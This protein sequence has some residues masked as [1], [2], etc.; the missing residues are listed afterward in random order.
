M[1]DFRGKGF[2]VMSPAEYAGASRGDWADG[3]LFA[4]D[5]MESGKKCLWESR[6]DGESWDK[7]LQDNGEADGIIV[8]VPTVGP[9]PGYPK[10]PHAPQGSARHTSQFQTLGRRLQSVNRP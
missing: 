1:R 6:I 3:P 4:G 8:E 7:F 10:Y 9:M 2:R 5:P